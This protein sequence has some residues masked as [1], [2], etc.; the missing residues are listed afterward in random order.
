MPHLQRRANHE[1]Q[2]KYPLISIGVTCCI[3][4]VKHTGCSARPEPGASYIAAPDVYKLIAENDQFRVIL[5]TWK[6]GQR[7]AW[8]SHAPTAIYRLT[9]CKWRIYTP[10]G[11]V[12]DRSGK[13]GEINFN[14][15]VPSHSFENVGNTECSFVL[16][17]RK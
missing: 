8:H 3:W 15:I 13:S 2:T 16:V 6:P 4:W 5:A 1:V 17:E 7:D 11:K 14:P 10:D 12:L 9:D